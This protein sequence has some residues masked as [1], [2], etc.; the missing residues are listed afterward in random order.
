MPYSIVEKEKNKYKVCKENNKNICF[1][2]KSLNKEQAEKQKKAIIINELNDN[3]FLKQ[4]KKI[5]LKDEY[6]LKFARK[7]AKHY[8]YNPLKLSFANDNKHKLNYDNIYFG[9]VN[10]ND[11]IIYSW[12]EYNNLVPKGTAEKKRINYKK[13]AYKK[14][15]E[16]KNKYSPATL[17]YYINW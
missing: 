12:L 3:I 6:Y 4:L 10:Y 5:N 16:S 9:R 13:R 8:G 11:F 7:M 2:N 14:M 1:S 15:V 17:A